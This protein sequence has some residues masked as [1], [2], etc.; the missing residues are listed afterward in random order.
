V[1]HKRVTASAREDGRLRPYVFDALW[2]EPDSQNSQHDG[3]S[4][5]PTRY[6]F[7]KT[8]NAVAP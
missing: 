7:N 1:G 8:C 6:A 4:A 5:V 3:S 2:A